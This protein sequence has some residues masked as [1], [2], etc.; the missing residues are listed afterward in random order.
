MPRLE[1]FEPADIPGPKPLPLVGTRMRQRR[2]L[3]DPVGAVLELRTH[4]DVVALVDQDPA[5]VCAFGERVREVLTDPE[6]FRHDEE[7]PGRPGSLVATLLGH[8]LPVLNGAPHARHRQLMS[9]AFDRSAVEGYAEDLIE[10]GAQLVRRWPLEGFVKADDLCRE[11][12]LAVTLKCLYGV[13][14]TAGPTEL[15][16][17]AATLFDVQGNPHPP[18]LPEVPIPGLPYRHTHLIAKQLKKLLGALIDHRR[19]PPGSPRDALARL[20]SAS[21]REG[22]FDEDELIGQAATLFLGSHATISMAVSWTLLLLDQH[23]ERLEAIQAEIDRVLDERDPTLADLPQ[24]GKLDR[25]IKETLRIV[26]VVPVLFFRVTRE[27][28]TL[29]GKNLPAEANVVVS[30]LAVHHDEARFPDPQRFDPDRWFDLH[31]DPFDYLPY[32]AGPRACVG[33]A[34]AKVAVPLLLAMILQ[35]RRLRTQPGARIDRLTRGHVMGFKH[36]LPMRISRPKDPTDPARRIRG[37]I[38]QLVTLPAS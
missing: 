24:L 20:V 25:A 13:D 12:V 32:G 35:H 1:G 19:S 4:G 30:P 15:G 2:F 21:H 3:E 9:R 8:T 28:V 38:H 17:L 18:V 6:R 11:L 29:G 36:G 26:P 27:A 37:D 16:R 22:P 34:F 7:T 23:P 31:P 14:V 33:H 10:L 5:I